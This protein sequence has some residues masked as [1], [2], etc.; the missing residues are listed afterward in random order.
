MR[1]LAVDSRRSRSPGSSIAST[2]AAM[3]A[4]FSSTHF[5]FL[6]VS[7]ASQRSDMD[8]SSAATGARRVYRLQGAEFRASHGALWPEVA[9]GQDAKLNDLVLRK[10]VGAAAPGGEGACQ[11]NQE[12]ALPGEAQVRL[13]AAS[14][15]A[16]I[17]LW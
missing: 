17:E 12:E 11:A 15:R 9:T 3:Q 2:E 16:V 13:D 4:R 14:K 6:F 1:G 8:G 7:L 5:V 10:A